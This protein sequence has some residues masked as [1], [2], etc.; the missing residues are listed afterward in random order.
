MNRV[1]YWKISEFDSSDK[2]IEITGPN[3]FRMLVDYDD[4][5]HKEVSDMVMKIVRCL[6]AYFRD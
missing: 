3:D 2:E 4:V 1:K 6:N 5:D